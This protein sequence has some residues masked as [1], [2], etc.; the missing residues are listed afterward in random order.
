MPEPGWCPD[1]ENERVWRHWDGAEW[2]ERSRL[3]EASTDATNGAEAAET[4]GDQAET[5]MWLV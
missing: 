2:G 4:R 5:V 1:P 3:Y